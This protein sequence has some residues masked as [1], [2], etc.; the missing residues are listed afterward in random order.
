MEREARDEARA[1]PWGTAFFPGTARDQPFFL[2][3]CRGMLSILMAEN[4][5]VA[6]PEDPLT[7]ATLGR[8]LVNPWKFLLPRFQGSEF[9]TI[10]TGDSKD[11]QS[12]LMATLAMVG[13]SM[14][15]MPATAGGRKS[16]SVREWCEARGRG[17]NPG[18]LFFT[19]TKVTAEST[20]PLK[21]AVLDNIILSVQAKPTTR[22]RVPHVWIFL[23]EVGTAL[24][25]LPQLTEGM[26]NLR[27]A[28]ATVVLG[29]HDMPQL[30]ERYDR[31]ANT[32]MNQAGTLIA[33]SVND[34][35][36][37]KYLQER[38]GSAEIMRLVENRPMH[39]FATHR[40]RSW[41]PQIVTEPVVMAAEFQNRDP[42]H[43]Y[44]IH[45]GMVLEMETVQPDLPMVAKRT[46]RLIPLVDYTPS[47]VDPWD[48]PCPVELDPAEAPCP[49][50]DEPV[51]AAV[52]KKV[53]RPSKTQG[54]NVL[55]FAQAP[56]PDDI[57]EPV[58][59]D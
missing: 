31:A 17:E 51:P 18:W 42:F 30:E 53:G 24:N 8:W 13:K 38:A 35:T 23:D 4:N 29:I 49:I 10:T 44:V 3:N 20:R 11:M 50:D 5:D 19:S 48:L 52:A 2:N 55:A 47:V 28:G 9:E 36:A 15:M 26:T 56:R 54:Q 12:G 57:G 37:A 25:R 7:C 39:I 40:S 22:G 43:G 16:F 14:R 34:P 59:M 21:S 6:K 1:T 58:P 33:F 32:V 46:E 41:T 27:K 45:R